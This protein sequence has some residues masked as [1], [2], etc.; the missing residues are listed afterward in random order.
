MK[1]F[2]FLNT[3]SCKPCKT[4]CS[5]AF[6]GVLWN[7]AVKLRIH[8]GADIFKNVSGPSSFKGNCHRNTY[9]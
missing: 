5:L 3:E 9:K 2:K 4:F 1:I 8:N 7:K 6:L